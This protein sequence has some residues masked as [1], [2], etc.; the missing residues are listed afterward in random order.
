MTADPLLPLLPLIAGACIGGFVQGL[1]GFA[2][3]LVALSFWAW[4]LPPTLAGP[5]AAFC[6]LVGQILA[7]RTVRRAVPL[8]RLAPFV[9]CGLVGVPV[10]VW[11]LRYLDPVWFRAGIGAI[12]VVYCSILLLAA[13][14]PRIAHGGRA[15]DGVVGFIG[16]VMGGIGGLVGVVPTLWCTL[17][18]WDKDM[19]RAVMQIFFIVMHTLTI[20][21]Y[22]V[23]G[24]IT[25]QTLH[26]FAIAVPSMILPTLAG[27]W[28]YKF[29]SDHMFRRMVLAL[30]ACS[31]VTLLVGTVPELLAR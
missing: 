14:L 29:L 7:L 4:S 12:L 21:L 13:H 9:L 24:V 16:G 1:S 15:A 22:A 26:V 10:G 19:Q 25:A 18:G 5:L 30:L 20:T 17:R 8:A 28:A 23:Q 11:I 6:S 2:F 31:G 27:A 3:S